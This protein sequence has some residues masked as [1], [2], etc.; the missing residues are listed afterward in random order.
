MV[1]HLEV[2]SVHVQCLRTE[3]CACTKHTSA[4][5]SHCW[6]AMHEMSRSWIRQTMKLLGKSSST[7]K[8]HVLQW[9]KWLRH[10]PR[11]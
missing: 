8:E 4:K 7:G 3:Q 6:I 10:S 11:M 1:D 2:C 5:L 9:S